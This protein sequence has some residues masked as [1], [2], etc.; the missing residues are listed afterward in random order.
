MNERER[1]GGREE[2]EKGRL[3]EGKIRR[4]RN[5]AR[6]RKRK[7]NGDRKRKGKK[8]KRKQAQTS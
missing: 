2:R 6:K 8:Y 4:K 1:E 7:R 3:M 5:I